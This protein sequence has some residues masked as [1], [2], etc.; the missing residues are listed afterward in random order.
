MFE[1]RNLSVE[2]DEKFLIKDLSLVLNNKDKLAIIGEEGNGK[3]TLLKS[4]LG[5][6]DYAN[7]SGIVDFK[8][9]NAGYL[10]QSL[11]INDL[12]LSVFDFLFNNIDYY[13]KA[14]KLYKYLNSFNLDE[15]ILN[16]IIE[17]LSGGEKVKIGILKL[18]LEDADI[19]FLDEP[20]NDLDINTLE[21]LEDFI[22][23][24]NKPVMY[25]S[26][27]E[28]FLSKTANM[29][30]HIE[31]LK[32]KQE[33]KYTILKSSY[34]DYVRERNNLIDK[35]SQIAKY[36]RREYKKKEEKLRRVMDKVHYEQNT[37][38]RSDPHG[39]KVLKKKMYTLKSQEK[40]LENFITT[41]KPDVEERINFFFED[42][43]IPKNKVIVDLFIPS[44]KVD[45]KELSHNVLL[46]VV[47][48]SHVCIIGSN[49]AGKSTLLKLIYENLKD[50]DDIILGYM[51]QNYEDLFNLD[52]KVLDYVTDSR[53]I[54][55]VTRARKYLGSMNFTRDEMEGTIGNLSNGSK[56]KLIL[57][58]LVLD[59]CNVL[60]LDEPTRNV[61]P[62]S[63]PVIRKVLR[64][65]NGTIISVSH[66]RNFI[67]EVIDLT[68]VLSKDGLFE[69]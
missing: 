21:W 1:I 31:Q 17:T 47:G 66:D 26:H 54:D 19:L 57:V 45:D 9:C 52:D 56:A 44:L 40:K 50:R 25:V 7:I 20:T 69:K 55:N 24:L 4:I 11:D 5:I 30:L 64:E 22:I 3:S 63:N 46:K 62:L 59:K 60:I 14:S 16:Q 12:K 42:S 8:G 6:C 65:F 27:D 53:N 38:T 15:D 10:P 39:A 41:F 68:Y 43:F 34:D 29:I 58:K 36:E 61:S 32:K 18:L 49:G 67:N 35:Q 37:I 28:V 23:N 51:P 48:N 33:C 13:E 2:V